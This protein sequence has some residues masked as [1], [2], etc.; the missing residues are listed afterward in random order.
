MYVK[1]RG[2]ERK[3]RWTKVDKH[4]IGGGRGRRKGKKVPGLK[5]C[6]KV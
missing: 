4:L 3:G 6:R 2:K 1:V 5:K